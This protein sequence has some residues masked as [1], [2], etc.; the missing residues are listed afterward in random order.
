MK[1]YIRER[2]EEE[3]I[4]NFGRKLLAYALGRSLLLSDE[5]LLRKLRSGRIDGP[6]APRVYDLSHFVEAIVTSPQFLNKRGR[7]FMDGEGG[8]TGSVGEEK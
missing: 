3:F 4:D 8:S 2:R 7:N 6:S 5:L 1:T